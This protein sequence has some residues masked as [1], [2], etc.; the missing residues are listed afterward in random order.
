MDK[1]GKKAGKNIT[2]RVISVLMAGVGGQG[3]LRASDI[4][5][6]VIME[7][8]L[9]VKKSEVHGMAQRGGCVT[10]HVRYGQKVYSPIERKGNVE[11][12][13]AFEKLE[14]LR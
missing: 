13:L 8:G 4:L 12:L 6:R 14:A 5:C 3:I 1:K 2:G 11:I 10:S 7:A 9:D